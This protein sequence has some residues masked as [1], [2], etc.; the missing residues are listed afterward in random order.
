MLGE[1]GQGSFLF[2]HAFTAAIWLCEKLERQVGAGVIA[3]AV[4]EVVANVEIPLHQLDVS[5]IAWAETELQCFCIDAETFS[6]IPNKVIDSHQIMLWVITIALRNQE[7]ILHAQLNI[8]SM[9]KS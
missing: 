2:G 7:R 4:E 3:S 8:T 1:M 9:L 5:L 6:K